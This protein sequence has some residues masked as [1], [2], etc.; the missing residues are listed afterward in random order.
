MRGEAVEGG[1]DTPYG[2]FA[3]TI[4]V[5]GG[6]EGVRRESGSLAK[7]PPPSASPRCTR[8]R[9]HVASSLHTLGNNPHDRMG[10]FS[11]RVEKPRRFGGGNEGS[12]RDAA[13]DPARSHTITLDRDRLGVVE[14]FDS[15]R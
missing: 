11:R 10:A 8:R 15:V 9:R 7:P 1:G 14:V 13:R 3:C 5:G 2:S 12:A 6:Q 4:G